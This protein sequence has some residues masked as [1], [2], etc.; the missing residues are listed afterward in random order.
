M[1]PARYDDDD[2][3]IRGAYDKFPDF[4][5]MGTFIDSMQLNKEI[6]AIKS[7]LRL[8]EYNLRFGLFSISTFVGYLTPNPFLCK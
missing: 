6:K 2:V 5:R 7:V 3:Y 1:L 8:F 4:F